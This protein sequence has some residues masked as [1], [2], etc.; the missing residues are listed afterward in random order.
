MLAKDLKRIICFIVLSININHILNQNCLSEEELNSKLSFYANNFNNEEIIIFV[1][2]GTTYKKTFE[3]Y[4]N[5][6]KEVKYFY[7]NLCSGDK[8]K[9]LI[10]KV[11][12]NIKS[13]SI[14]S[15]EKLISKLDDSS[16]IQINEKKTKIDKSNLRPDFINQIEIVSKN[17]MTKQKRLILSM[18]IFVISSFILFYLFR[19]TVDWAAS[20]KQELN[21]YKDARN[22]Y[23]AEK[24]DK[25][26]NY[27]KQI[28]I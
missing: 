13:Y 12:K 5:N 1:E 4:F 20:A 9:G 21:R 2:K 10:Y 16:L 3:N 11:N 24:I 18:I 8:Q 17:Q 22:K 15:N 6:N 25:K 28:D 14:D 7:F 19:K 27:I 23:I 26:F